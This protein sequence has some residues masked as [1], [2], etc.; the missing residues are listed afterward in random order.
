MKNVNI[1]QGKQMCSDLLVCFK[2]ETQPEWVEENCGR[3]VLILYS[4]ENN[5]NKNS[6]FFVYVLPL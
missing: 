4:K 3:H 2:L 6:V 5:L 1:K